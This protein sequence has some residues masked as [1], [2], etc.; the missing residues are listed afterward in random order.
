MPPF[1]GRLAVITAVSIMFYQWVTNISRKHIYHNTKA[2][3]FA[4]SY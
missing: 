3:V 4:V 2:K 1:S